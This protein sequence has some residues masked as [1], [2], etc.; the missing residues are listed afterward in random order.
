MFSEIVKDELV[1]AGW[2]PARK[3]DISRYKEALRK[4]GYDIP[5][6]LCEFLT[7]YGGLKLKIPH[8]VDITLELLSKYP[9]LKPP[10]ESYEIMH[11]DVIEA[12]GFPSDIPMTEGDIF[13]PRVGEQMVLFG[14]IFDGRYFLMM[15]PSGRIYARDGRSILFLGNTYTDMFENIFHRT[16]LSEIP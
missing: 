9:M 10:K 6:K 2:Y 8:F 4:E 16:V 12:I 1:N 11:F 13:E 14:E 15:T 5:Q 7:E 3:I